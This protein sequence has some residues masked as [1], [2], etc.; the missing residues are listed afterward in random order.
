MDF[1]EPFRRHAIP[2][3]VAL[4]LGPGGLAYADL[5]A[6]GGS[7]SVCLQG[8]HLTRFH[9]AG[10]SRPLVWLS[11]EARFAPGKSIRGGAPVCWPWFGA[12][13]E[14]AD[15]P[16]HGYARTVPWDLVGS[17]AD[18]ETTSVLLRLRAEAAPRA[19][20][21]HAT[22]VQLRIAVSDVLELEL[23]TRNEGTEAVTLGEALHTYLE[24]GDIAQAQ[25]E[26]LDGC[27]YLDKTLG[28]ARARQD[29]P[30]AFAGET[31]RVYL[32]TEASC[33][34]V[35]PVLGRR[36]TVDKQGSSSTIVWTPW[37]ERA[38]AM[39]DLGSEGWRR[40]LCVESGNA[41]DDRLRLEP[42]AS[43]TLRAR[44]RVSAI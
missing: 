3:R 24:V 20:W 43:H 14:H 41:A 21:P 12:H 27:D 28:F 35:D 38:A 34:V 2:A 13:A 33:V 19:M 10:Q 29:G 11:E 15:W 44:Y 26:G 40:M 23:T 22:P 4:R 37:A 18:A 30:V 1:I 16:A 36:I 9:P 6:P 31:D 5:D 39:G 7:A 8:A 32:A 17:S 25:L 42:G